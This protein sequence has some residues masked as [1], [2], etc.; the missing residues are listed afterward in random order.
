MPDES[1]LAALTTTAHRGVA[2]ELFVGEIGDQSF[3]FHAQHSY[4]AKL[5]DAGVRI[6]LSAS[7]HKRS[8][9]LSATCGKSGARTGD[10]AIWRARH[11]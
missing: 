2:V 8:P 4:Y 7:L 10:V 1:L 5:L 3:V 9:K 11:E 6:H